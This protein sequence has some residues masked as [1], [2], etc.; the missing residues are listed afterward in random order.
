[1]GKAGGVALPTISKC[2]T[3]KGAVL[4]FKHEVVN[5]SRVLFIG[6]SKSIESDEEVHLDVF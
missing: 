3:K 1:M 2:G 4:F 6:G 5:P